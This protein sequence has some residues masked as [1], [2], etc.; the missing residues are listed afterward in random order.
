MFVNGGFR[1]H[2]LDEDLSC[3]VLLLTDHEGESPLKYVATH[4]ESALLQSCVGS[5]LKS[6]LQIHASTGWV[7]LKGVQEQIMK[8]SNLKVQRLA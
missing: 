5:G 3:P 6:N 1:P 4:S 8:Q 7:C 2:M